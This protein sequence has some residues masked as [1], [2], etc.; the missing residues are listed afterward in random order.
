MF[1]DYVEG[2]FCEGDNTIAVLGVKNALSQSITLGYYEN[3]D[4]PICA[5]KSLRPPV[6]VPPPRLGSAPISL[7]SLLY[8]QS[9][10]EAGDMKTLDNQFR[11]NAPSKSPLEVWTTGPF[12]PAYLRMSK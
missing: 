3:S 6:K 8:Q 9:T 12:D 10:E 4:V 11:N 7:M 5:Y 1:G 2:F